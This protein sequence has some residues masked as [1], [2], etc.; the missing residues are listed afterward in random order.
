M[1]YKYTHF[2]PQNIAPK[3]AKRIVV[4]NSNGDEVTDIPLG[5]LAPPDEQEKRYSFGLVSDIHLYDTAKNNS[6]E[7]PSVDVAG[8]KPNQKFDNALTYFEEM[9]C[10]FC[11]VCGDLTQTGFYS[12]T[13]END[14]STQSPDE[15]QF[16]KYQE[17]RNNHS[18][19]VYEIAG[20]HES[21]YRNHIQETE[22]SLAKWK[23]YTGA[24]GLAYTISNEEVDIPDNDLFIFIGQSQEL[25]PMS[26]ADLDWLDE[27][28]D[29]N[30]NKRCFIFVHPHI[31]SGNPL[32]AYKSNNFFGS[33]S[34]AEQKNRFVDLLTSHKNTI[35]F[36][37]HSHFIFE[38][39]RFDKNANYNEDDFKSV[40]IPSLSKPCDIIDGVR[41]DLTKTR[42][43]ESQGYIVDVYDDCIVLNGMAFNYTDNTAVPVP[44]GTFKIYTT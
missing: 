40:H 20:N 32:G 10:A 3:G 39:Q 11:C 7:T 22:G 38:C 16:K 36:H 15:E 35:L 5:R 33:N 9:K 27:T 2:I 42:P 30:R 25:T 12:R 14:E 19:P 44:L 17:I 23:T 21:Y 34:W 43:F 37:G 24:E 41:T 13:A 4:H 29:T 18:I 31:G 1:A 28:L 8:F 6:N 26:D